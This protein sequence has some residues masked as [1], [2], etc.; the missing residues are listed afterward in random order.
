MSTEPSKLAVI[1]T[2]VTGMVG[3]GVLFE[4]LDHPAIHRVLMVN[5]R[6]YVMKHAKLSELIVPDFLKLDGIANQLAGF[7]ACFFC[8]GVSSRGMSEAEYTRIT[9][10]T[11]IH[12]A[13]KL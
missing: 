2:G 11:T 12:F 13:D 5:R 10:D 7:D 1:I 4:C 9:F 3:E 6:P 8:A